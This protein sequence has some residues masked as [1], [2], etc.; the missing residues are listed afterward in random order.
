MSTAPGAPHRSGRPAHRRDDLGGRLRQ[1]PVGHGVCW[2][3]PRP[4]PRPPRPSR[5]PPR[6]RSSSRSPAP[7][8]DGTWHAEWSVPS[9]RPRPRQ[10]GD[11]SGAAADKARAEDG[12]PDPIEVPYSATGTGR[13]RTLPVAP[14]VDLQVIHCRRTLRTG[15]V[16]LRRPGWAGTPLPSARRRPRSPSRSSTA[17]W[18]PCR[19]VLPMSATQ[20]SRRWS[21]VLA[22]EDDVPQVASRA[23]VLRRR[24]RRAGRAAAR[25]RLLRLMLS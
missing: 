23:L 19:G 18:S 22:A 21:R 5:P 9:R 20:S 25:A 24:G 3:S 7:I 14:D 8:D 16:V 10:S 15:R 6:H 2:P 12:Q 13:L 11:P 1:L 17:R 4:P